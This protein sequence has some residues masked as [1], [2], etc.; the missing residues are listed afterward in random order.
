[1]LPQEMTSMHQKIYALPGPFGY[2]GWWMGYAVGEWTGDELDVVQCP[3]SRIVSK[4]KAPFLRGFS[5][6]AFVNAQQS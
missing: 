4:E 5:L 2:C 3:S 1:M 6:R